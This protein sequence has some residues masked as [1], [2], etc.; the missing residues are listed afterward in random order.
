MAAKPIA[1][2]S[3]QQGTQC[4]VR[5]W[6]NLISKVYKVLEKNNGTGFGNVGKD[7]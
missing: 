6:E 3:P 5:C 1:P 7:S 2:G 4:F